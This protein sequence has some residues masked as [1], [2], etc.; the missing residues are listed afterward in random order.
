[1]RTDSRGTF[2]F[3]LVEVLT[4][5]AILGGVIA[6]LLVA[7]N[8]AL[9]TYAEAAQAQRC[10]QL[11]ASQAA[12]FR[13]GEVFAG[14]GEF[15]SAPGYKWVI[16]EI[17]APDEAVSTIH[18]YRIRVLSPSQKEEATAEVVLWTREILQ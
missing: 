8:N 2:G 3:T 15:E 9:H 14:N 7:R 5:V 13:A 12:A 1:M 17:P 16:E 10:A 6:L 18:A 4:A 11:C